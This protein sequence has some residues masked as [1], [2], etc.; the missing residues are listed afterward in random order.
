M[1]WVQVACTYFL[2]IFNP[3]QS[4]VTFY[5]KVIANW[6]MQRAIYLR[7]RNGGIMFQS[8]GKGIPNRSKFLHKRKHTQ[9]QRKHFYINVLI[10][11][12]S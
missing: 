9:I 10:M 5:V 4:G 2:S 11:R 6:P 12:S 1:N 3:Q 7:N 8:F